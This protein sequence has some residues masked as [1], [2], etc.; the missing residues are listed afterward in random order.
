VHTLL[1]GLKEQQNPLRQVARQ[2]AE[3]ARLI[4]LDEFFVSD[5]TDA[6]LLAG[7]LEA[8]FG[9][10]V[11]LLTTSN[12]PPDDLYRD[13]LQR[14][15]FLPAIELLK[16]HLVVMHMDGG[17]DYRLLYL[18]KAELYH[19]PWDAQADRLLF[20][21]FRHVSPE[22]GQAGAKLEIE[23]RAIGT[24]RLADGVVWFEFRDICDGPRSQA[25]YLEIARCFHTVLISAVPVMDWRMENQ[26][27]RFLNLIDVFYDHGVK[28]VIAA[29]APPEALYRGERLKFEYQRTVSRLR[30]MQS[31]A[32]LAREHLP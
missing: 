12:M 4:C 23:G 9:H 5:I 19:H 25:D 8:L 21:A 31:R 28:L 32:Y 2:F 26:A 10:G 13:G 18:E 14:A 27:R 3:Q 22:A 17:Q 1:R 29:A 6:M 24:R 15:R 7:L 30:E 16:R 20:D 11:T